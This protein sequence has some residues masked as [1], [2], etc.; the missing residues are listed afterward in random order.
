MSDTCPVSGG[1]IYY[2][3]PWYNPNGASPDYYKHCTNPSLCDVP[4]NVFGFQYAHTGIAYAGILTYSSIIIDREYIQVQLTDT[5]KSGKNY[6]V[7]FYVNL[8]TKTYSIT[9][10]GI[11]ELGLLLT[12]NPVTSGSMAPLP[13]TPQITSPPLVYLTDTANWMEISGMYTALGGEKYITIGNFKSNVNTDTMLV[14]TGTDSE[15]RAYY[16]VDD[17]SVVRC[18]VGVE[19]T[20]NEFSVKLYPNPND[21]NM[22]L[23]YNITEIGVAMF[24]IYDVSGRIVKEQTFNTENKKTTINAESLNAGLYYYTITINGNRKTS[25][26]LV[27]IK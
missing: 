16:Y 27:I 4:V 23:E 13:Y 17:V 15:R 1:Q 5:L 25:N 9:N 22:T 26:K 21:G 12:N 2:A 8:W 18:N 14:E 3:L 10:V 11:T 24:I 19:E 6:C 20:K 7:S